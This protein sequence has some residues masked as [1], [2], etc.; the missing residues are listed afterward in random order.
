MR[1]PGQLDAAVVADADAAALWRI[2]EDG[3]GLG[4]RT[5]AG[6]AAWPGWEDAAV[7]PG[8]LA[9][10]LREFEAL[11]ARY[12]FDALTYGHFGDGCV[13]ARIDFPLRSAT[14]AMREFVED[15]A[16][17]VASHGGSMSGEHGDGRARGELLPIMYSPAAIETFAAV[18]HIFDPDNLL[19]PGVS[20]FAPPGLTPTFGCQRRRRCVIWH[21]PTRTTEAI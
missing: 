12:Q 3:A 6:D 5:P 17:L 4:S 13:H 18:K 11:L 19:N 8:R 20:S 16:H 7:P 15:A 2:R 9:R 21:S 14:G 10:Y 1:W